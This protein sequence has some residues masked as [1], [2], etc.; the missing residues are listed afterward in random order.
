MTYANVSP[1]RAL[2]RTRRWAPLWGCVLAA[3]ALAASAP[4]LASQTVTA[5]APASSAPQPQAAPESGD[6]PTYTYR[7]PLLRQNAAQGLTLLGEDAYGGIDFGLRRDERVVSARL[8]LDYRYSPT[9]LP[10][11]SH[12]NV[13]LNSVVGAT[14]ALPEPAPR[15]STQVTV[16]LPVS[17]L[18]EFN[19]LN[20]ELIA[21]SK[22]SDQGNDPLSPDL[23]LKAGPQSALEL[24]VAPVALSSDLS[25]LPAPFFDARDVR[26]LNLPVVLPRVPGAPRLEA[27]GIVT[28]WLGAQAGYRGSHFS[29]SLGALPAHGHAVVLA[30][31]DELP[32]LGLAPLAA[33][34]PTLAI[35]PNPGDPNGK[36]LLVTGRDEAQVRTAATALVLGAKTLAGP[37]VRIDG[38]VSAPPRKPFDAPNWLPGD[39]PVALGELLPANRFTIQGFRPG[40]IDVDLRLPPGLFGFNNGG[41]VLN[42]HYRYTARPESTRS[43]LHV[44][45]G[46]TPIAALPLPGD[47]SDG[48]TIIRIPTYLLPPLTTLQF[49]YRYEAVK[50]K[51]H[52]QDVP[53]GALLSAIDPASTIDISQLPRYTAMPDLGAFA[54]AGFP[55]TRLADLSE[56][57]VILPTQPVADDYSAYLTLMGSMGQATGYPVL[58]VTVG[59]PAEVETLRRK[60][61]LVLAS[62]DNQPLLKTWRADLPRGFFSPD[63]TSGNWLATW[64]DKLAGAQTQARREADIAALYRSDDHD[65]MVAGF[66]SPLA[67]G[68]SVVLVSGNTPGGLSAVADALQARHYRV[69]DAIGGSLVIV[70]DGFLTT[71]NKDQNYFV[72]SLPLRLAIEW[73]FASHIVLLL[74]ATLVS[75]VLVGLLGGVLLH[76]RAL[77]RLSL[78][79]PQTSQREEGR[80]GSHV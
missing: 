53:G 71:L 23:W 80:R 1:W 34:G 18:A 17:L 29:A 41:A 54:N 8:V 47:A 15:T 58:G 62:G 63:M 12:L 74:A 68:R 33:D 61:L 42:L 21:H 38:P 79:I 52:W 27:A 70:N 50:T 72:G 20:L 75:V 22:A 16:D 56:T 13:L 10:A 48:R 28:S 66:E 32:G 69:D 2:A 6:T 44:L 26:R 43:A 14:I 55:F 49:D 35:V 57:A 78:D 9:L 4:S 46:N 37:Q 19:H 59:T 7:L 51:D 30:L 76:R 45:A 40:A 60:D 3:L 5:E 39:R 24:T 31:R 77:S 64:W 25:Q 36:L 65:G 73:F 11:L 67:R